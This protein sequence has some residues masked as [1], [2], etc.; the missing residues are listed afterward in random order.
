[1]SKEA[2]FE[3]AIMM[4]NNSGGFMS[5]QNTL[6][7]LHVTSDSI[8]YIITSCFRH[9]GHPQVCRHTRIIINIL[10][11]TAKYVI[12]MDPLWSHN[13]VQS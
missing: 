3:H 11:Y 13:S 4:Q 7:L 1:M 12:K 10:Q 5:S 9:V 2:L 6:T 8:E